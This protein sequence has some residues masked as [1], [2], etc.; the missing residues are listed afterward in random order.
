MKNSHKFLSVFAI[1][2]FIGCTLVASDNREIELA[3][4]Q[5]T[6]LRDVYFPSA[7]AQPTRFQFG[8]QESF[9]RFVDTSSYDDD[10]KSNCC[11]GTTGF[12]VVAGICLGFGLGYEPHTYRVY[13][14]ESRDINVH[15]RPGCSQTTGSG[16]SKTTTPV[17]CI[18]YGVGHNEHAKIYTNGHLTEL[19]ALYT[20]GGFEEGCA[21]DKG[22]QN[23]FK[24]YVHH[25]LTF[26]RGESAHSPS[27]NSSASVQQ[28]PVNFTA[29]ELMAIDRTIVVSENNVTSYLRGTSTK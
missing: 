17:D 29:D 4:P 6:T 15:Y 28:F 27:I 14:R 2:L 9:R 16:K 12:L 8:A 19:C 24:W 7:A 3:S 26:T 11:V 20:T 10:C 18:I 23:N 5:V 22:L 21:T 25:D 1:N 13:N